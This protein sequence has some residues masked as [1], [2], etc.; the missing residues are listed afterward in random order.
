[1]RLTAGDGGKVKRISCRLF[2]GA[3]ASFAEDDIVVALAHDVFGAHQP[4]LNRG[5]HASLQEDRHIQTADG[6]Q[7]VEVL[8]VSRT[9]LDEVDLLFKE[10]ADLCLRS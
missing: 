9:N 2:E 6:F 3:D 7:K 1:M 5:G 4:F 10:S 8:H